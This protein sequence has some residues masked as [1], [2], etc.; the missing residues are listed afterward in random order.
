MA[1]TSRSP[2]C[3]LHL[4]LT[5]SSF[6]SFSVRSLSAVSASSSWEA[7]SPVLRSSVSSDVSSEIWGWGRG[8]SFS[9]N[10]GLMGQGRRLWGSGLV[11][12]EAGAAHPGL[13]PVTV[14][15]KLIPLFLHLLKLVSQLLD[16]LLRGANEML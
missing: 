6:I 16:L 13:Q 12:L 14:E 15:P 7:D 5:C 4:E 9:Q 2:A 1:V 11:C 8:W 3:S 10:S